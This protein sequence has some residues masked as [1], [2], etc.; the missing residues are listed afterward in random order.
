[1]TLVFDATSLIYLGK[2][3]RLELLNTFQRELLVPG[4]VY[5][6]LVTE[7]LQKG[8]ADAK[9]VNENVRSGNL[10][11]QTVEDTKRFER[12][13]KETE[14]SPADTAVLL[15]ADEVDGVAVMDESYGRNIA[16][17]ENVQTRGTAY[18]LLASVKRHDL[19]AEEARETIDAMLDAGWYCAPDLY[20]KILRK[21]DEIAPE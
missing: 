19:S 17:T 11:Q 21:L 14:L 16:D 6:E 1:M 4:R 12:L 2:V 5:Q 7:G 9:R 15:L 18:L 13:V 8:Y 20:A 3:N 10:S